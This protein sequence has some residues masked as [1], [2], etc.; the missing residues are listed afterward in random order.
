MKP[1]HFKLLVWTQTRV[2]KLWFVIANFST[3]KYGL[4][5]SRHNM[6]VSDLGN[7]LAVP[8]KHA[9][10]HCALL[11]SLHCAMG[12]T[13]QHSYHCLTSFNVCNR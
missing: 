1:A 11:T 2:E 9:S 10:L 8:K 3:R 7:E 4:T 5:G 13:S 12:N 6:D